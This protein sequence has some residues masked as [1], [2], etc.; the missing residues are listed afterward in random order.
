MHVG[1]IAAA[2]AGDQNLLADTFGAFEDNNAAATLSR[3]DAAHQPGSAT[4]KDDD[5]VLIHEGELSS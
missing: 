1:E 2:A 4:S 5:V 3:F